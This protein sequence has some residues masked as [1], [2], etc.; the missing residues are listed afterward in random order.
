MLKLL[1]AVLI[2]GSCGSLGL[3]ARQKLSI[4][5]T[6]ITA[7]MDAL[8]F[9]AAELS[10]QQTPLPEI[11][12]QL[13]TD[14]RRIVSRLFQEMKSR[15][16]QGAGMS[17]TYHWQ[18]SI[19]DMRVDLGLELEEAEILRDAANYLGRY[20]AQQQL[21]GLTHTRQRLETVRAQACEALRSKGNVYRTCGIAVGI[22]A[23]LIM[24]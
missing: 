18:T 22:M 14:H 12:T 16:E 20:Q 10:Y 2:V 15:M 21:A 9:I 19:R 3:A 11:V 8:D 6:A 1:G 13:A 17:L 24:L 5:I 7:L 4:R 23:V